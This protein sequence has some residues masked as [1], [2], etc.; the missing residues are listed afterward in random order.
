MSDASVMSYQATVNAGVRYFKSGIKAYLVDG[1]PGTGKTAMGPALARGIG[2]QHMFQIK[3]S[4]HEVPDIAGVPVPKEETQRTHFYA[5]ADMLPPDDLKGGCLVVLDEIGDCNIAQQNLACQMV[6]EGRIHNYVFPANTYFFLTSNRVQDRSG[7]NRIVT[8]LGNRIASVT[9]RPTSEELFLYG[10]VN[11][12]NP[13]VL[14]FIKMHGAELVN[15]SDKR[16]NAPTY[17]NSF[18]PTDPAQMAKPQFSSSRSL[19]FT[20]RYCNYVDANEPGLEAGHVL[21]EIAGILG[22][23]VASKFVAFRDV[24]LT[25]PDPDAILAGKKV[26]FPQEQKV[27]WALTLTLVSKVEKD[28]VKYMHAFLDQ[29]PHE[30]LALAARI[31]FDTKVAELAGDALHKMLNSPKLK[32]MFSNK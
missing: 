8:K 9:V 1:P 27:L 31:A 16:E 14:A 25:M 28:S 18:D 10:A 7:A 15:P 12:W 29:G 17:F 4:H 26:P 5:S 30:Y 22:T 3:L 11:G 23:P 13:T 32:T 20:S 19:E 24:A 6:F 21:G 2:V